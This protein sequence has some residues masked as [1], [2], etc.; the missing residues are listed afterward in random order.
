MSDA[1]GDNF[2][3][4]GKTPRK[5][6]DEPAYRVITDQE[7]AARENKTAKLRELRLQKEAEQPE[8]VKP[9]R[10]SKK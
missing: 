9:G 7:A 5:T 4:K 8:P 10:G 3:N 6:A 1:R 2:F